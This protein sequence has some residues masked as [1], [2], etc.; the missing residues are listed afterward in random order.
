MI[1]DYEDTRAYWART[2]FENFNPEWKKLFE[3]S[4]IDRKLCGQSSC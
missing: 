4:R 1:I 3:P 2:A